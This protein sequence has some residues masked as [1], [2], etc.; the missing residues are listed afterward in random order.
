ML[1]ILFRFLTNCRDV[2]QV[3]V[4]QDFTSDYVYYK[5]PV[6]WLQ[7]KLLRLLQYYPPSGMSRVS[8]WRPN[9]LF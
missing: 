9:M 5:V 2:T 8:S 1:L 4:E 6:P 3:V 7:V